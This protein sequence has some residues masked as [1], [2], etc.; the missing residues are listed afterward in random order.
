MGIDFS[1]K[2]M[3]AQNSNYFLELMGGN[4]NGIVELNI[5]Q[6]EPFPNQPFKPYSILKLA[7][8]TQDIMDNGVLSP[9]IV[10]PMDSNYQILAGHNR[11]N[12]AKQIGMTTI[13]GIIK[14]VD[15]DT[16]TIIMVNTN[17]NQRDGLLPSEKAFAYK[18]QLEALNHNG[19]KPDV[20]LAHNETRLRSDEELS[21]IVGLSRAQIQRTVR[22]TSL[23]TELLEMV[24]EKTL[25]M[26]S[27]VELSYLEEEEQEKVLYYFENNN[28]KTIGTGE[29]REIRELV[30]ISD[31]KLDVIFGKK[32]KVT[33]PKKE[34]TIP[35]RLPLRLFSE[36]LDG[37]IIDER[38]QLKI[39][40][41]IEN[42]FNSP[43]VDDEQ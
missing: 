10:R 26:L 24:D 20:T 1:K 33:P 14:D 32:E 40:K 39:V 15:D 37:K 3:G 19:M 5:D 27:G 11:V 8:L 21:R 2:P 7:E 23:I 22:L 35:I 28:L 31:E 30:T 4:K 36:N 6:L 25:P 16:A 34:K 43:E 42:Y 9:I 41:L 17:L 12:A 29:A 18:M 13:P 38:L